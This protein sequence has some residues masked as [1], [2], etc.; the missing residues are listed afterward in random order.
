MHNSAK[1][2]HS[3]S[4]TTLSAEV[5]AAKDSSGAVV[6]VMLAVTRRCG[7]RQADTLRVDGLRMQALGKRSILPVELPDL[8]PESRI[9][10]QALASSGRPLTVA[11]FSP[12]GMVDAYTLNVEIVR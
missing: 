4:T 8:K 12:L 6:N 5:F 11:E 10:L 1:K 2:M 9:D 3:Q 7:L